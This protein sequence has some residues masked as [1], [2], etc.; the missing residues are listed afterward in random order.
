MPLRPRASI[1][2]LAAFACA[3]GCASSPEPKLPEP[4]TTA[5]YVTSHIDSPCEL[6]RIALAVDGQIQYKAIPPD[7]PALGGA[8]KL[9]A[10][11]RLSPGSHVLTMHATARCKDVNSGGAQEPGVAT[12]RDARSFVVGAP[13]A[14]VIIDLNASELDAKEGEGPR[15]DASFRINGGELAPA[16]GPTGTIYAGGGVDAAGIDDRMCTGLTAPRRAI[17]RAEA[18]LT[19]A[20]ERKD[21][22]SVNC[23]HDKIAQM[24]SYATIIDRARER[25]AGP[26]AEAAAPQPDA[27][28]AHDEQII[29]IA[30]ERIKVLSGEVDYCSGHEASGAITGV[31]SVRVIERAP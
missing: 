19:R 1:L 26:K 9:V 27:V 5:I 10:K 18:A 14:A 8:P 31:T 11:L 3:A 20:R 6:A 7:T 16:I 15:L 4:G 21:I 28:Q 25:L 30:E 23:I 12:L 13:A 2:A 24:R 29:G 17:C 22:V